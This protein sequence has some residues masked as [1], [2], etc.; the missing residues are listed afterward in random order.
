MTDPAYERLVDLLSDRATTSPFLVGVAGAVAVGKTTIVRAMAHGLESRGRR[1][2]VLSTDAFLLPNQILNEHGLLMR[3]GFP[4]SYDDAAIGEVLGRLRSGEAATVRVYS[5]EV[6]DVLP[7]VTETVPSADVVLV[8]GVV[9]LQQPT[10]RHLDLAVYIDAPQAC[11][12]QWFVERFVRLTEAGASDV[13]SFYHRL[14][15]MPRE[16]VRQVAEAAWDGINGPNLAAHIA[17]SAA[18]ADIVVVKAADHS[19]AELRVLPAD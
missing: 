2:R 13:S 6:Y 19:I 11:V 7:G 16:Q 12:R 8:E 18:R 4:E 1:V 9:A 15:S 3:K 5:H 10:L 14:A 17:P